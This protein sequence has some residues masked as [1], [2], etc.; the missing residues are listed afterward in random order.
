MTVWGL[1]N[2]YMPQ[3]PS[4]YNGGISALSPTFSSLASSIFALGVPRYDVLNANVFGFTPPTNFSYIPQ[5]NNPFNTNYMGL[6]SFTPQFTMPHFFSPL[7]PSF[8]GNRYSDENIFGFLT[9]SKSTT[10][11]T[12]TTSSN[13]ETTSSNTET[14]RTNTSSQT[15]SLRQTSS[16][17]T[18]SSTRRTN[19][20]GNSAV[21]NAISVARSQ[22]GVKENGSSNNS[23]QINEYRN[24]VENGA[25][26]CASFV[27]WCYGRGQNSQN[28]TTF[29]YSS[30]SQEIRAQAQQAG[31]YSK[32]SSGYKPQAGDL[33]ILK[34]SDGSGHVGIV[35]SVNNDGTFYVIEGNTSNQVKRIRRS[36]NT[37]KLDGFV[38]MNEWLAA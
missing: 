37:E 11:T 26:W 13:T 15:S 38:R 10:G 25:P 27:S 33:M 8:V 2:C 4:F 1:N 14:T 34:Y 12:R 35:E 17:T 28:N 7:L 29:G 20:S 31:V 30:S 16:T 3:Y 22:I 19:L 9:L 18:G 23:S 24:G 36:M 6:L 32:A 5:L 21:T